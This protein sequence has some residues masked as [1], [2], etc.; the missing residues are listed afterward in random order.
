MEKSYNPGVGGET[1]DEESNIF[2]SGFKL[3]VE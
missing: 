2:L 1:V 3:V